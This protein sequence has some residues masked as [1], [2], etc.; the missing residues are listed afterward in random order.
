MKAARIRA[1]MTT[2]PIPHIALSATPGMEVELR[3]RLQL[4]LLNA[5]KSPE[6]RL[7]LEAIGFGRFEPATTELYAGQHRILQKYW[8]F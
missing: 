4:A 1:V 7:M 5:D 8:G 3:E 6:G 2:E